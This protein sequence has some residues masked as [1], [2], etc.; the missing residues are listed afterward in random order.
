MFLSFYSIL[1]FFIYMAAADSTTKTAAETLV[2]ATPIVSIYFNL[3]LLS[4]FFSRFK[5]E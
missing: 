2:Y 1:I 3:F 5:N 4:I